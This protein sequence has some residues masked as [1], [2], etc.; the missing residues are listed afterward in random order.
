MD[1]RE[2]LWV[3]NEAKA[4]RAVAVL[5]KEG[6]PVTEE[7]VKEL[8]LKYGGLCI[9]EPETQLGVDEGDITFAVLPQT[10]KE[11]IIAKSASKNKKK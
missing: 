2:F 6:K 4:L 10:E 9:G 3:S 1:V 11:E 8:Y 7:A 5:K